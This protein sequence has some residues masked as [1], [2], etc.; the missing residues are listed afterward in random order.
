MPATPALIEAIALHWM[1]GP[2]PE[3]DTMRST[4]HRVQHHPLWEYHE[5]ASTGRAEFAQLAELERAGWTLFNT[6]PPVGPGDDQ[7]RYHFR[8]RAFGIVRKSPED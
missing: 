5:L 1:I 6:Q 7:W 2:H 3:G 4:P 8:R